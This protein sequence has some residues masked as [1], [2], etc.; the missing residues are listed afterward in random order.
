MTSPAT[1][2]VPRRTIAFA[3]A[4]ALHLVIVMLAAAGAN[5]RAG[6]PIGRAAA[7]YASLSG[8]D[9][10]HGYFAPDFAL[11]PFATVEVTERDGRVVTDVVRTGDSRESDLRMRG[12]VAASLLDG[13][14]S[15]HA[16]ARA[17]AGR[18]LSQHPFAEHV[19]VRLATYDLPTMEELRRG[20]Q[21][22]WTIYYEARFVRRVKV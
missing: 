7:H 11:E 20:A 1:M 2:E 19:I 12:V 18:V 3:V 10:A 13:D 22:G 21:P 9:T 4:A 17:C 5:L 15:P 6:G 8:A 14:A 16:L